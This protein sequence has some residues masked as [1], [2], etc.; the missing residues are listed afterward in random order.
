M[1]TNWSPQ[2]EAALRAVSDWL[3]TKPGKTGQQVF[4]VLRDQ[5]ANLRAERDELRSALAEARRACDAANAQA[6]K[7]NAAAS[8][9]AKMFKMAKVEL[10]RRPL[11]PDLI[12]IPKRRIVAGTVEAVATGLI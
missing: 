11:R 10:L 4:R 7:A 3:K 6:D 12:D 5:V 1:T 2:Q 8:E 9:Y